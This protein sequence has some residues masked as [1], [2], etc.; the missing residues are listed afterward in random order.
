MEDRLVKFARIVEAGSFTRAAALLHISQPA[1][2]TAIKKLERE[3]KA[4]LLIRSGHTLKLTAAGQIAYETATAL[5]DQ[6]KD[7]EM[8][9]QEATA[10]KVVLN[11]GMID[12]LAT[13]LFVK[14]PYFAELEQGAQLS[15][16][17]DNSSRLI[18]MVSHNDLDI[19]LVAKP[20]RL[21][22][23][24]QAHAIGHEPLV[25][26]AHTDRAEQVREEMRRKRLEHCMSY[27]QGSHTHQAIAAH[28]AAAG[29]SLQPA[30]YSTSPEIMLQLV[31]SQRGA[32]VLPYLLVKPYLSDG[33]MTAIPI[34]TSPVI[35]REIVG[36]RRQGRSL[37]AQATLLLEH[38][39]QALK[40][41]DQAVTALHSA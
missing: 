23:S 13:M 20:P 7:L 5:V 31:L 15:L 3:L 34:G 14:G 10:Q 1:L 36:L 40:T 33:T 41:L 26:V 29:I 2:T 30:F 32:A 22:A 27:N 24:L 38:T 28:F 12:S 6:T 19:A 16:T 21:Q 37:S 11:L 25:L 9:I 35:T 17:I 18:D 39:Q 8:R 4:E